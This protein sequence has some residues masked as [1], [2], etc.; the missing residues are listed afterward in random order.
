MGL[1]VKKVRKER[2]RESQ[3][4][5]WWE[6]RKKWRSAEENEEQIKNN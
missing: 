2:G 3:E 6:I 4:I 1:T 5:K